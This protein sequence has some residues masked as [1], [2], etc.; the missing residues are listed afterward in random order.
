MALPA[1]VAIATK[2]GIEVS[3]YLI[4]KN[5]KKA[6][7]EGA[8]KQLKKQVSKQTSQA[9]R[10]IRRESR[11]RNEVGFRSSD[12]LQKTKSYSHNTTLDKGSIKKKIRK[13]SIGEGG[14]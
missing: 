1:I 12:S 8:E 7:K 2:L 6:L 5:G 4:K 11:D 9:K 14:A 3:K 13:K 10:D